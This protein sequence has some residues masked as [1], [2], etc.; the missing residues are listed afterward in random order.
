MT[1]ECNPKAVADLRVGKGC[2][3]IG[4]WVGGQQ[5][6]RS[7]LGS[8]LAQLRRPAWRGGGGT[9]ELRKAVGGSSCRGEPLRYAPGADDTPQPTLDRPCP[10]GHYRRPEGR[11]AGV[12]QGRR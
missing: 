11:T 8:N 1:F 7:T 6:R 2:K 10:K 5:P 12:R 3:C 9:T 4:H